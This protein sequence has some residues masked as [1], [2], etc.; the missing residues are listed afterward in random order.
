MV[1]K[2]ACVNQGDLPEQRGGSMDHGPQEPARAGVR[3]PIVA[4]KLRNGS[5]AKGAQE[6]GLV[7]ASMREEKPATVPQAKQVGETQDRWSWVEPSVWTARMLT[8]LEQGVK[9]GQWFSLIDK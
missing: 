4:M 3:A 9:G 2:V 6:G 8:A 1:R 7:T 5:G